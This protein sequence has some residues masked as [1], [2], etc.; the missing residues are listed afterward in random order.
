MYLA[1]IFQ[2]VFFAFLFLLSAAALG[3]WITYLVLIN[4][5]AHAATQQRR[6][7][8]EKPCKIWLILSLVLSA[9]VFILWMLFL[10]L[11][12]GAASVLKI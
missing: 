4:R 9:S 5:R 7:Q 3:S 8:M 1:A 6:D 10:V 2:K 11:I 12:I